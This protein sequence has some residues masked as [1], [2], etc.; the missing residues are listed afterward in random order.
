MS[1]VW[2]IVENYGKNLKTLC[3]G[4]HS[5]NSDQSL[6]LNIVTNLENNF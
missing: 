6:N 1:K 2:I 4:D 5:G 3:V